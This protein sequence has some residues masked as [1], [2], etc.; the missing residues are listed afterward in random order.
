MLAGEA[1]AATGTAMQHD[2]VAG[3]AV[4]MAAAE[5]HAVHSA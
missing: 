5:C 1:G 2:G 4:A 3:Y